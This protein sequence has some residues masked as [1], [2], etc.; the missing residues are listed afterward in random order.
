MI[1]G[2]SIDK[3]AHNMDSERWILDTIEFD[4]AVGRVK[5]FV[6]SNPDTLVIITA[7]HGFLYQRQEIDA[8]NKLPMP[9]EQHILEKN[10]RYLVSHSPLDISGT[11][12]FQI[13]HTKE[14]TFVT[15]PRGSI[16]FASQG[17]GAQYVHGGASLQEVC[18]PA[19]AYHHKRAQKNGEGPAKK[20][21]VQVNARTRKVTNNRFRVSLMQLDAIAGRWRSRRVTIGLYDPTTNNPI[22][23]IKQIELSNTSPNPTEREFPIALTVII[24]NP[25][26]T[27]QLIVRDEDDDSELINDPWTVSIGI[28][29]D[30]GDF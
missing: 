27:A 4:N 7:D 1:E 6:A 13:P 19:L 2:A 23:D 15:V 12:S 9:K 5:N 28:I 8:S 16:R 26:S 11:L 10:R 22:T 14:N 25:P 24:T 29:N 17:G 3:Q 20:V 21:E 30:F 18:V